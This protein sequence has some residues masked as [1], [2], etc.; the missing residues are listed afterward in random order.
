MAFQD[1]VVAYA[2]WAG[3][4]PCEGQQELAGRGGLDRTEFVWGD[5]P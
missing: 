2:E 1:A 5:D 4:E 3:K